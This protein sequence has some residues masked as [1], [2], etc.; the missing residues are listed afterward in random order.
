M[1]LQDDEDGDLPGSPARL[2]TKTDP[3]IMA[4]PKPYDPKGR[5]GPR[6][7]SQGEEKYPLVEHCSVCR[8]RLH[9]H[10]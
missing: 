10:F 9:V 4:E 3:S 2:E 6:V 5:Q 7:L 1:P 8:A